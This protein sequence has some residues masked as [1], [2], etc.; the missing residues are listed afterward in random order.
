MTVDAVYPSVVPMMPA[1]CVIACRLKSADNT[2]HEI[3]V[4][5]TTSSAMV[6]VMPRSGCS[7]MSRKLDRPNS[8]N[9]LTNTNAATMTITTAN[10][11]ST[12][13]IPACPSSASTTTMVWHSTANSTGLEKPVKSATT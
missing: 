2:V 4:A 3:A 9:A 6:A 1:R 12:R 5:T 8:R 10:Q 11:G 7:G 13:W